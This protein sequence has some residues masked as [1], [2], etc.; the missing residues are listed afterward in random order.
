MAKV[1]SIE[2]DVEDSEEEID[3]FDSAIFID[4]PVPAINRSV[5]TRK[6]PYMACIC[7]RTLAHLCPDTGA[8]SNLVS[9]RFAHTH[10]HT[11]TRARTHT[12]THTHTRTHTH[13]HTHARA[14]THTQTHINTRTHTNKHTLYILYFYL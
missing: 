9:S 12:H 10:T 2:V 11:H 13:T 1:R 4:T 3:T 8:E 6:S 14:Y 5:S 7:Q